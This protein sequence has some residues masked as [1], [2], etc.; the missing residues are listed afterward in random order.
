L[1]NGNEHSDFFAVRPTSY[2]K[3]HIE[4][5]EIDFTKRGY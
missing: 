3:G 5:N 4:W 2:S 1:V